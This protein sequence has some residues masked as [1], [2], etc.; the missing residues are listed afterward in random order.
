MKLKFT[1]TGWADYLY[2]QETDKRMLRR[3][4]RLIED[5]ERNGYSGNNGDDAE[6]VF[7]ING[8]HK[9]DDHGRGDLGLGS[10]PVFR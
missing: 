7:H 3:I 6:N 8:F 2:W 4:N 9:M 5:I 10:S 1:E